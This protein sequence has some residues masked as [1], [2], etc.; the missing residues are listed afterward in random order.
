MV[1][2]EEGFG[3]KSKRCRGSWQDGPF[4]FP[5]LNRG[6]ATQGA[7]GPAVIAGEPGHGSGREV[8][9]NREETV[10]N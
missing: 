3:W 5:E 4:F 9:Q 6:G 8:G 2:K 10:G 7:A 1:L